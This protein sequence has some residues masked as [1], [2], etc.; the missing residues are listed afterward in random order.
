MTTAAQSI[1]GQALANFLRSRRESLDPIRLGLPR[2]GRRRTPGLR[3]EEVAQ[4]ANVSTTWYTWLEQG[5]EV[6]PSAATLLAIAE[7]LQCNRAETDHLFSLAQLALPNRESGDAD[8][9]LEACQKMLD[10]LLPYPAYLQNA[11]S[12]YLAWNAAID[13]FYGFKLGDLDDIERNSI[14]LAFNNAQ[15][16]SRF[17]QAEVA[18]PR[19]VGRFRSQ[20]SAHEGDPAWQAR[21]DSLMRNEEF[22][23]CWQ[24]YEISGVE[25]MLK[26]ANHPEFGVLRFQVLNWWT[27]PRNGDRMMVYM[28]Q[29]DATDA[30]LHQLMAQPD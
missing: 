18:L 3:R 16:R 11:R 22:R 24:R 12:D 10:K 15:L 28:P 17:T 21:L 5:R 7:A 2:Q 27:A 8:P 9:M 26:E 23:E 19:M 13:R 29:D 14:F 30:K 4:L 25:N 1:H 6:R 20:M